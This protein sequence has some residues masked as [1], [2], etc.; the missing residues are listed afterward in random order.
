VANGR[1]LRTF[2]IGRVD[3]A[4]LPPGS[5]VEIKTKNSTYWL[6]TLNT[7]IFSAGFAVGLIITSTRADLW[8]NPRNITTPQIIDEGGVLSIVNHQE[9]LATSTSTI[10]SIKVFE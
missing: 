7:S 2:L 6:T 4:E 1:S 8:G 3:L 5:L 9:D 10:T